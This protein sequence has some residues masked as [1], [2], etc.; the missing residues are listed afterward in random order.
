MKQNIAKLQRI[1][2]LLCPLEIKALPNKTQR[3]SEPKA[4]L[5]LVPAHHQAH[6]SHPKG[7]Q[8]V[9]FKLLSAKTLFPCVAMSD[10]AAG[11]SISDKW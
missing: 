5:N 10:T 6:S 11:G 4:T 1:Y 8:E 3:Y 7:H 2:F 9:K